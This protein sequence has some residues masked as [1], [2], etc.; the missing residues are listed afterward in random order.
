MVSI[1]NSFNV[2]V[3]ELETILAEML[4]S[5]AVLFYN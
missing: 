2:K 5:Y 1:N 3:Y 4:F